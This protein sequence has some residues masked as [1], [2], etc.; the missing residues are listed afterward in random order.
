[1]IKALA[2]LN[3]DLSSDIAFR[4]SSRLSPF[5]DM[6][7][8]AIH[9]EEVEGPS[10]GTG[11]VRNTLERGL[12]HTAQEEISGL[13]KAAQST[14]Q[15][16]DTPIIRVGEREHELLRE[17]KDGLYDLFMEGILHSYS[18]V[19]FNR[20][21]QSGLYKN[22]LCPIL[23][24]KNLVEVKRTSILLGDNTNL[25]SCVSTFL[26]IFTKPGMEI[27]LVH[28]SFP[29]SGRKGFKEKADDS[30]K[31]NHKNAN[32]M[33]AEAR[34]MLIDGG[35][36]RKESWIIQDTPKRINEFLEDYSL[37]VTQMPRNPSQKGRVMELLSHVPT[38]M[39]LCKK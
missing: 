36:D 16:I 26:K 23:L 29:E 10:P 30:G 34:A 32:E 15:S 33:L 19:N 5:V 6:T 20:R 28:F 12:L 8:Q 39:L 21:L 14:Y 9:V 18:P 24:V 38:A 37:V 13:I 3:A 7:L 4:Y 11:W 27:D 35:Q 1:M 2:S 17:I 25:S 31:S 22:A